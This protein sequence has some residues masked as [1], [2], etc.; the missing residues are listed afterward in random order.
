M[1]K[2]LPDAAQK[3]PRDHPLCKMMT[4]DPDDAEETPGSIGQFGV[5]MKR[6]FF[7]L[8]REFIVQ[9]V[10]NNS[11]FVL[12]VDVERWMAGTQDEKTDDWHFEFQTVEEN[13]TSVNADEIG[14]RIQIKRLRDAVGENFELENFRTRLS[15]EIRAAHAVSMDRGLAISSNGIPIGPSPERCVSC[16]IRVICR[17]KFRKFGFQKNR[18]YMI[19]QHPQFPLPPPPRPDG[20]AQK[21]EFLAKS[22]AGCHSAKT[23]DTG[24]D[25]VAGFVCFLYAF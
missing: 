18:A 15:E 21:N 22:C 8:G 16:Y 14:T 12:A 5:G 6:S 13:L 17:K 10:T 24:H 1:P 4:R 2:A 19:R 9:S 25:G 3:P 23:S 11:R 7:K 20:L